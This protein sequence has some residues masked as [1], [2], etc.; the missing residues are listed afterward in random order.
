MKNSAFLTNTRGFHRRKGE[1]KGG[2]QEKTRGT[3]GVG[4]RWGHRGGIGAALVAR[5]T[6]TAAAGSSG[7][8]RRGA[9]AMRWEH[10]FFGGISQA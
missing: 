5:R 8:R 6:G 2:K 1:I 3:E 10:G 7:R 4:G 9:H